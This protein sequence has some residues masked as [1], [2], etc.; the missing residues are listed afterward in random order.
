MTIP[1]VRIFL[2]GLPGAGKSTIGRLLGREFGLDDLDLDHEIE[3]SAHK[4]I[5]TLFRESGEDH[6]RQLEADNLRALIQSEKSFVLSTGG[7]TP[8]FHGNMDVMNETGVTVYLDVPLEVIAR[9]LSASHPGKNA[10]NQRPLFEGAD[11][12]EIRHRVKSLDD[13]RRAFY[14]KAHV[15]I[16][17]GENVREVAA[18]IRE[19]LRQQGN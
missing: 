18:T 19:F 6:F 2:V 14:S 3:K 4:E 7:G 11:A 10:T 13:S 5:P 8:C 17:D 9:R 16:T 12:D 15:Q 1:I